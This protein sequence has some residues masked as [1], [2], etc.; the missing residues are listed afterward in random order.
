MRNC[1]ITALLF[2]ALF[3]FQTHPAA[4][5]KSKEAKRR[6]DIKIN[7]VVDL[8]YM[9]RKYAASKSELPGYMEPFREAVGVARQLNG[10][11]GG[12]VG[13]G[14]PILD[15]VLSKC[16]NTSD[17]MQAVSQLP[18]TITSRS[19][20]TIRVREPAV[21]YADSLH[22]VEPAYLK[23]VWPQHKAIAK[24]TAAHIANNF[25]PKEQQCFAYLTTSLGMP[26]TAY[27]VPVFLVVE[28]P[29]PGAFT[30]WD[31]TRKGTIVVSVEAN[32]GSILYEA[33]LHEAIHA[34][35][36]ETEGKG[37]L[38]AE[39]RARLKKA[40]LADN[41]IALV[42]GAHLIVFMQA[43]E[44]IR[45][46]IEPSHRHYGDV[47]GVY[48]YDA[49]R[50]LVDVARPVWMAYLDKRISRDEAINQIVEGFLRVRKETLSKTQPR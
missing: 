50:P 29:W 17:A 43:G 14:W 33:L 16:K 6:L 35:D 34:L 30:F 25:A 15:S 46:L 47:R 24:R 26:D 13:G 37:N 22:A 36:L 8:S 2:L 44:T 31:S 20:T 7:P 40:G 28:T 27:Q 10:E 18:E 12:W 42:Q 5:S 32:P 39:I 48:A 49:L 9:I 38:L 41:D 3:A 11:F 1:F 19:G 21:R 4:L 45:R 23:N